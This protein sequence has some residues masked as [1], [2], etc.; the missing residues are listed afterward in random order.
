M[1]RTYLVSEIIQQARERADQVGSTFVTNTEA[2]GY[3]D[4]SYAKLYGMLLQ[5]DPDFF[6]TCY[7]EW[8]SDG[9]RTL[10]DVPADFGYGQG[11]D[12]DANGEWR[13][14]VEFNVT[15]RNQ[16]QRT[17]F[18]RQARGFRIHGCKIEL[19]PLPPAGQ[20]YRLAYV[21]QPP[22]ITVDTVKLDGIAGYEDWV[23]LD[24][25]I[26]MGMKENDD[27]RP[28]QLERGMEEKRIEELADN[29]KLTSNHR[30]ID[31][32]TQH[33]LHDPADWWPQ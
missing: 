12:Y 25:A 17:R 21:A 29:R 18:A 31:V 23:V 9:A 27:V 26:K 19:G 11:V 30:V 3:V 6:Q 22:K 15:E 7:H 13:A 16:F 20:R 14:L 8:V 24:V 32:R 5:A 2:I 33:D 28:L 4:K 10:Y 1:P